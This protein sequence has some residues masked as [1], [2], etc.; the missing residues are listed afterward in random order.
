MSSMKWLA[1]IGW[2]ALAGCLP[3]E[4]VS[5]DSG[6]VHH[7]DGGSV[8]GATSGDSGG[9]SCGNNRVLCGSDCVD[10]TLDPRYC[11]RCDHACGNGQLCQNSSCVDAPDCRQVACTGFTYCDLN[12]G[13]CLVGCAS[14][15]QCGQNEVCNLATHACDCDSGFH[16][17]PSGRCGVGCEINGTQRNDGTPNPSNSCQLCQ[18]SLDLDGW[19]NVDD[20]TSCGSGRNCFGGVCTQCTQGSACTPGNPC[21]N[22]SQSCSAGSA[23][24]T[25]LGTNR[26][27]GASCGTGKVCDNG[28]CDSGCW[29][30]GQFYYP[31][32][33]AT[34]SE[35][36]QCKPNSSTTSWTNVSNGTACGSYSVC[37]AGAC[38]EGCWIG[39]ALRS[40][41]EQ[42]SGNLCQSCQRYSSTSSWTSLDPGTPCDTGMVCN[43]SCQRGCWID[44]AFVVEDAVDSSNVCRKCLP[45]TS[46][47]DWSGNDGERCGD[48]SVCFQKNCQEGCYCNGTFSGDPQVIPIGSTGNYY[49]G[50]CDPT[51]SVA[52]LSPNPSMG[53]CWYSSGCCGYCSGGSCNFVGCPS[54]GYCN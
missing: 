31:D 9:Q 46:T 27:D 16:R 10:T 6:S 45:D 23:I 17:F 11:G 5:S 29:L 1:L 50:I 44:G 2:F 15:A 35:C 49:C 8:D 43:G 20:G 7:G 36:K 37:H 40:E 51:V 26:G 47:T 52:C 34:G 48:R 41:G 19:S 53:R 13:D 12:T 18:S 54:A 24:C 28:S 32:E 38:S 22:G 25:D 21:H 42:N 30:E 39:G 33:Y 3:V 14:A 4:H